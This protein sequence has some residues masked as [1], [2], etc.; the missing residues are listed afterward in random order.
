MQVA[1]QQ[2][3][4]KLLYRFVLEVEQVACIVEREAVELLGSR[5]PANTRFLFKQVAVCWPDCWRCQSALSPAKP[6]PR[7]TVACLV[8]HSN[9]S[10]SRDQN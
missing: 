7:T 2:L 1:V 3:R 6:P 4:D 8:A 5:E 9:L 10:E